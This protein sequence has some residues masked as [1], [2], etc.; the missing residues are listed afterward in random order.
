M[1]LKKQALSGIKWTFLQQISVQL[2]NFVVQ[3]IL[4]RLLMP[5][6][7]GLIAMI[8]ILISVGQTLMDSGMT[9]SLIRTHSP[10]QIDYSTVFITN[11]FM[12]VLI[13]GIVFFIAPYISQFYNQEIL[14]EI[15]R[16]FAI[17]FVIRALVAVH[18]AKLT[19]EMN[20][21]LQMKLQIPSSVISGAIGVY[22]AYYG[23][24]VWSLVY[25][26]LVQASIFSLHTWFSIGWK[27]SLIFNIERFKYHFSFGYK[28]TLASLID[29]IFN[30]VYRIIIGK[31]F[32]PTSLGFFHQAENLRLFPVQQ[33]SIV[34]EKVTYPLF[35]KIN[36][37][38]ALKSAYRI[39]M[40]LVLV[41]V[42]PSML[43]LILIAEEG[44]R[45]LLGEKW[46]AA[47][48]Y[49]QILALASIV[50]P[51]SAYNLNILK[52]KGRSEI[53]LRIEILKK[54]FGI[55]LIIIGFNF[56]VIGL[57]VS[58]TIFSFLSFIINMYFS[59]KLI[60]YSVVEQV[61]DT[62]NLYIIGGLVFVL[63]YF[64]KANLNISS[65][66]VVNIFTYI[67]IFYAMY[68]FILSINDK[69]LLD[70]IRNIRKT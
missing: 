50:R 70:T 55:I 31:Y 25:L 56:H 42:I 64:I 21:R 28:L 18:V 7:F 40:K 15:I 69:S 26:N 10:N 38:E 43:A 61:K 2:I 30:D 67:F 68:Y 3:I 36:H 63:L 12:S 54:F 60:S 39:T 62:L 46:L 1:N 23:Y 57:V 41:I 6:M 35:S 8:I 34:V 48:P 53:I 24:G 20:F 51:V 58:L 19:K 22:M 65:Y 52:V 29:V 49:F 45:L 27:P 11:L 33:I 16:V 37:D 5:E 44:F 47:V 14:T 13:Y 4:A 59:G 66:D 32:S 17:T 9:S